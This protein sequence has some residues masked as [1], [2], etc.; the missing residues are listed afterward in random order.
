MKTRPDTFP[1]SY[2]A[3]LYPMPRPYYDDAGWYRAYHLD[4]AEMDTPALRREGRRVQLRLDYETDTRNR[5][6]LE[7]RIEQVRER[8]TT[9]AYTQKWGRR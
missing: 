3:R 5:M 6:W 9:L 2:L 7:E 8:L 4:L 1:A